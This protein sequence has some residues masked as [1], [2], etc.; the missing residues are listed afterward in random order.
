MWSLPGHSRHANKD[1]SP[2][3]HRRPNG[4][5]LADKVVQPTT[6]SAEGCT[7]IQS[8]REAR[9]RCWEGGGARLRIRLRLRRHISAL[10]LLF[11][12]RAG[13]LYRHRMWLRSQKSHYSPYRTIKFVCTSSGAGKI[14]FFTASAPTPTMKKRIGDSGSAPSPHRTS[15]PRYKF[16]AYAC[17][18]YS[19]YTYSTRSRSYWIRHLPYWEYIFF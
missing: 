5:D 7:Y 12:L 4:S 17:V 13:K 6:Q 11:R 2:R 8:F 14:C 16:R 15:Q 9:P 18:R 19:I 1:H 10:W 3:C